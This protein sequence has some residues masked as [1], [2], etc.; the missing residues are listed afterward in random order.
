MCTPYS[1]Y[2]SHLFLCLFYN[3]CRYTDIGDTSY[4]GTKQN[5]TTAPQLSFTLQ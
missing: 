2:I 4:V 5:T 1:K 3:L